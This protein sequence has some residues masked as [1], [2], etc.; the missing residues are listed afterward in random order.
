MSKLYM[1]IVLACVGVLSACSTE[2]IRKQE[3]ELQ[4]ERLQR[5]IGDEV[6]VG[7]G[8]AAKLFGTFGQLENTA[9]EEYVTLV[10]RNISQR[11]GRTE[12]TFHFG[13]LNS[14]DFNAFAAPGGFILV[15]RG[16]LASLKNESEL[17]GVLS[18]EIAHINEKHLY[19]AIMPKKGVSTSE[20]VARMLSR[21]AGDLG[22]SMTAL[23]GS[24]MKIL[25]E[26]GIGHEQELAADELGVMYASMSGYNPYALG[27]LLARAQTEGK[28]SSAVSKTHP[29]TT[30]RVQKINLTLAQSGQKNLETA[31]A[32]VMTTRFTL[33]TKGL[34]K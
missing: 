15:S 22:Q 19:K 17:A 26:Q 28:L 12:I 14:N 7:R 24:S 18:H 3:A 10:G 13:I 11:C 33:A 21:G 25:L 31:N 32:D 23:I 8:V 16:L 1:L 6:N 27:E 4:R 9:L 34:H 20:T 5:E 2:S 29:A 30:N